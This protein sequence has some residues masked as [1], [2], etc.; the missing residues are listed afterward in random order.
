GLHVDPVPRGG[1]PAELGEFLNFLVRRRRGLHI[2]IL[3]WDYPMV[4]GTDREFPPIYG[5][6]AWSPRRRVHFEYDNTHPVGG[7]HHQKIVVIDD[8]V[9]FSGGLDLTCRRWDTCEHK[10]A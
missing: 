5:L 10:A 4:F 1:P 9:A 7:S 2:Y 6:G 3:N 8:A